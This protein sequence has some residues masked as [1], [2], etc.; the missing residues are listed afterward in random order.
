MTRHIVAPALL[1]VLLLAAAGPVCAQDEAYRCGA[2]SYSDYACP[3][4]REVGVHRRHETDRW[5]VPSQT[6]AVIA[7]RAR[8]SPADRQECYALDA[9]MREQKKALKAKGS[10]ATLQDEMPLVR[11][12]KRFRELHC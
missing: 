9:R 1:A 10:T 12:E 7:K 8:L 3:Q 2:H 11:S 6:R 4:G 5:Q